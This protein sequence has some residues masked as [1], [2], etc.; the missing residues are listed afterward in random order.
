VREDV[1]VLSLHYELA[2]VALG[3]QAIDPVQQLLARD[4]ERL[5]D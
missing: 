5:D 1:A 3:D 4:L 2:D